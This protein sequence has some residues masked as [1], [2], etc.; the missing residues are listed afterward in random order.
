MEFPSTFKSAV[1]VSCTRH[2]CMVV[3]WH[4]FTKLLPNG[5]QKNVLWK[6]L[7]LA[8]LCWAFLLREACLYVKDIIRQQMGWC[9]RHTLA[10]LNSIEFEKGIECLVAC[11]VFGIF[12]MS[13]FIFI[14][15]VSSTMLASLCLLSTFLW[16]QRQQ[17]RLFVLMEQHLSALVLIAGWECDV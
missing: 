14:P 12:G 7:T 5:L 3:T 4:R 10:W 17:Q 11:V 1:I 16:G 6:S 2:H 13:Q 8:F 9:T 15:S